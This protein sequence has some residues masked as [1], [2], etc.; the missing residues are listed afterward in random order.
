LG[1]NRSSACDSRA[2]GPVSGASIIGQAITVVAH[3]H[4]VYLKKLPS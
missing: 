4:H 2:F 3:D 1:D